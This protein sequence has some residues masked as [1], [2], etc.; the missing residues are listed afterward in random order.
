MDKVLTA[1]LLAAAALISFGWAR[2]SASSQEI[3]MP[4]PKR[5]DAVRVRVVT[6]GH[7]HDSDFYSVF[8]DEAIKATV[9]PHP[10]AFSS[11]LRKRADVLVLYDMVQ[12]L[13]PK[14]QANLRDFV[15]SGKGVVALHHAICGNVNWK[16][17]Y[18]EVVGG[19]YLSDA[20]NGKKS[21]YKHDEELTIKPAIQ[22]PILKGLGAFRIHD[23]TY[24]DM[25]ISPKVQVLLTTDN[26]TSDGPVAWVS[27]YEKSRVV[28][29][30]LGHDRNANLNPNWQRL[31]RNA[32]QWA[33]GRLN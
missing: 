7:D 31:V 8:D 2:Q 30:Q 19:R 13:E 5:S 28:Y 1:V 26:P 27:P 29:I 9:E 22:H 10:Q 17:W 21:S 16:W 18:E 3:W 33:A 25:W 32:I 23:E 20:I 14:K 12:D 15:E 24:K 6:G 11:D 4:K